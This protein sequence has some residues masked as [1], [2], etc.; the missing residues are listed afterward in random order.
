MAANASAAPDPESR[1][2]RVK[3]I[4]AAAAGQQPSDY[5]GIGRFWEL[6]IEEF[7]NAGV[8]GMRLIAPAVEAP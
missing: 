8:F 6:P 5:G 4:L 1:Y 2:A 3:A 7:L